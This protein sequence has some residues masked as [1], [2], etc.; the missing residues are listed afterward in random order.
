M[1]KN[2]LIQ[3]CFQ[4]GDLRS[5][6]FS[7]ID[8]TRFIH[9]LLVAGI[10]L[11]SCQAAPV[12]LETA[13]AVDPA[14]IP[15]GMSTGD[16][17]T[18]ISLTQ[19]DE[20][21]LYTMVYQ[22]DYL[23]PEMTRVVRQDVLARQDWGCS[24]FAVFGE[25]EEILLGRNFDWDFSPGLLLYTDPQDGY[26]S[27]SMVDLYYLGYGYEKAF[28]LADLPLEDLAGL[29]D[30]PYLPF[31]GMN[32][33]GLAIGMAAVPDG[34]ML[35]DPEKETVDSLLVIRMI[36]D[37]AATVAEAVE[38][39]RAYNIDWGSGPALHYLVVDASGGSALIEFSRG[40]IIV[41]ENQGPWQA[42]TNFLIS[43][44]PMDPAAHCWRYGVISERLEESVGRL[45]AYQAMS[46]LEDVSQENTQWSVVYRVSAGEVQIVMGK[47]YSEIHCLPFNHP[48][49]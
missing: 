27:V 9:I 30:A 39:I 48:K 10:L 25:E 2:R 23:I 40:E 5:P 7:R 31:D 16:V 46:L 33:T 21:P 37:Q 13:P 24:L 4:H 19:V 45:S 15:P 42:A 49:K 11:G 17:D 1:E 32:E 47:E 35:P 26:A 43:E 28:G 44:A 3:G 6:G 34:G 18:L 41:H 12:I 20:Y 22:A 8:P 38:I 29:L 36:L 14:L